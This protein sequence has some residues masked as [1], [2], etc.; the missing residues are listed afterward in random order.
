MP[1]KPSHSAKSKVPVIPPVRVEPVT[2]L[3]TGR[4]WRMASGYSV[5]YVTNADIACEIIGASRRNLDR[6]AMA[7][8]TDTKGKTFAW[9]VL[10]RTD[11]WDEVARRLQ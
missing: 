2:V 1:S 8:Y 10:I 11:R 7:Y 4:M 3:S 5:A 9:Q 6:Q